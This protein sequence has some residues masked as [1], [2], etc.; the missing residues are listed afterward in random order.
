MTIRN[1]I[2][3][4]IIFLGVNQ[5]AQS[6]DTKNVLF[7]GN[8][9]TGYNNL[10]A[11]VSTCATSA[12]DAITFDTHS[13]GGTTF[14]QHSTNAAVEQKISAGNWDFVVLQE[15]SQRPS[16]PDA[17]VANEVYPYAAKLDSMIRHHNPCAEIVFYMTW[18]RKNGDASNC[19]NWPPVC[20]YGGMDSL[21]HLRYK[22]MAETNDAIVA[23]VGAVWNYIREN[24][25]EIELY[26]PDES[27]PSLIGSY[28]A[29]CC[30]Y[31]TIFRKNPQLITWNSTLSSQ[32]AFDIKEAVRIVVF[33]QLDNWFIGDYD[34]VSQFDFDPSSL[35]QYIF[36]NMSLNSNQFEWYVNGEL[37]STETNLNYTFPSFGTYEITLISQ[38]CEQTSSSTQTVIYA[39][40]SG[41]VEEVSM[42]SVYPNPFEKHVI[43]ELNRP[44]NY[45]IIDS[46]G[47]LQHSGN[48]VTGSNTLDLSLLASG[49]YFLHLETGQTMKLVKLD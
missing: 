1:W 38:F 33:E 27:H 46:K 21:L 23:P 26:N 5:L 34:P 13:P 12:G 15:Q 30:F 40:N 42:A 37:V 7:I 29:A 28:V 35:P 14:L 39:P 19:P 44:T 45:V 31:T 3:L 2:L 4:T 43:L 22:I 6:Q 41:I 16:F 17:Q 10:A 9:Y 8:S 20:T 25:P 11:M 18:G 36:Q 32:M 48:F 47:V 24:H 49:M